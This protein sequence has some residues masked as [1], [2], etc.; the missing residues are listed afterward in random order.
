MEMIIISVRWDHVEKL[1]VQRRRKNG[2]KEK[3]KKRHEVRLSEPII[4][5]AITVPQLVPSTGPLNWSPH[6]PSPAH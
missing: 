6:P 1:L 4:V 3:R 2:K 5:M